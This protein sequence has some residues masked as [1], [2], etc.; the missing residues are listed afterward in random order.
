MWVIAESRSPATTYPRPCRSVRRQFSLDQVR[1][2]LV[3]QVGDAADVGR[4]GGILV[5]TKAAIVGLGAAERD[6]GVGIGA[7][8]EE[9]GVELV[10]EGIV[11]NGAGNE[12][13]G[14]VAVVVQDLE[15]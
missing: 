11:V 7:R 2:G 9:I 13:R 15:S 3:R 8:S 4:S 5:V 6:A 14:A 10:V 1:D 12:G